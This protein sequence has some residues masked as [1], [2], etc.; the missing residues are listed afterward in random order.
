M[1]WVDQNVKFSYFEN[2]ENLP[3]L[4]LKYESAAKQ[5]PPLTLN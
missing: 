5:H 2:E 1:I 4:T 3:Q